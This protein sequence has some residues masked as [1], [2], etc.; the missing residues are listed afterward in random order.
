MRA[1][2][3]GTLLYS[4][5]VQTVLQAWGC[6]RIRDGGTAGLFRC[7]DLGYTQE[8]QHFPRDKINIVKLESPAI[9][10][11]HSTDV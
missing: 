3:C 5:A 6:G 7:L 10:S 2:L 8:L 11:L 4:D 1:D 9:Q